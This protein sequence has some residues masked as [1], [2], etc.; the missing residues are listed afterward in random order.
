V[1]LASKAHGVHLPANDLA[2]SDARAIFGTAGNIHAVI[3]VS[4][5]SVKEIAYAEAHGADFAVFGPVFE[6]ESQSVNDGLE[7]LK[8]ACERPRVGIPMPVLALGGITIENAHKST[9][10]GAAGMAGIRLF[11]ERSAREIVDVLNS[12]RSAG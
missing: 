9:E 4:T 11:Q 12:G 10:A 2:A 1:A 7:R 6:K 5:H 8:R 3:G